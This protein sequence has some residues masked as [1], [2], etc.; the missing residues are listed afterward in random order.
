MMRFDHHAWGWGW[1]GGWG[2][3]MMIGMVLFWAAVIYLIV[4]AVRNWGG[5][6][7]HSTVQG[8]AQG[9]T[10]GPLQ[11]P[12]E[13]P[14]DILKRRYAAGEIDKAEFDQKKSDLTG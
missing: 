7:V 4:L 9:M 14:L 6:H 11:S 8:P 10:Q 12:T 13:A 1:G 5:G 2:V 3:L